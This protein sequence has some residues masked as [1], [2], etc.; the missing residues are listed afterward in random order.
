VK[1]GP[2]AA[3]SA[4][5]PALGSASGAARRARFAALGI[6]VA[7]LAFV[8]S[9]NHPPKAS[10]GQDG[11]VSSTSAASQRETGAP[12]SIGSAAPVGALMYVPA[13]EEGDALSLIRTK[14]LEAKAEG[15]VL[16]VYVG[17]TWCEPC[18]KMKE[19]I[20]AGRLD[21]KLGKTTF[22]AFDADR[23]AERLASAGYT[24]KFVPYVALPG[25]DGHPAESEKARGK[26]GQAWRELV[27]KLEAWQSAGPR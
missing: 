11:P 9:C 15:R 8:A 26:G 1:N 22:L 27:G 4:R 6:L 3:R 12:A 25:A 23:D 10:I 20:H 21:A 16:V 18:R 19:E 14:R 13:T 5:F 7:S 2:C 24:F 17:A